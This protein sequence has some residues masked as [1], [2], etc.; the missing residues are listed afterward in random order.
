LHRKFSVR[1]TMTIVQPD[2]DITCMQ[3]DCKLVY[4]IVV[5]LVVSTSWS[6]LPGGGGGYAHCSTK[7]WKLYYQE[8]VLPAIS[9]NNFVSLKCMMIGWYI[10]WKL[11]MQLLVQ[12]PEPSTKGHTC[13]VSVEIMEGGGGWSHQLPHFCGPWSII[14][15]GDSP[16]PGKKNCMVCRMTCDLPVDLVTADNDI[17]LELTWLAT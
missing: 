8:S 3:Y 17:W 5:G 11:S 14:V 7:F 4:Y 10:S 16:V 13:S 15:M 2:W 9:H 6:N 1:C 12:F